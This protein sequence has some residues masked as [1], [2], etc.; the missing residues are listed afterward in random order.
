MSTG[1]LIRLCCQRGRECSSDAYM[2]ERQVREH[3]ATMV[4]E[5]VDADEIEGMAMRSMSAAQWDVLEALLLEK[6]RAYGDSAIR[7][8]RIFSTADSVEQLKV[9]I[10]DKLSRMARGMLED[11][12]DALADLRGYLVLLAVARHLR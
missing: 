8:L 12:E 11:N 6:N 1:A 10:D 3:L 5:R 4:R 7:P 2:H 9:R